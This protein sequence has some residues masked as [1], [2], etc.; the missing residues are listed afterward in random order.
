MNLKKN[1]ILFHKYFV[2]M[3]IIHIFVEIIKKSTTMKNLILTITF[4][5]VSLVS[6]SQYVKPTLIKTTYVEATKIEQLVLKEVNSLV[7]LNFKVFRFKDSKV[8]RRLTFST[9]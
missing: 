7:T 8:L 4:I 3:N 2:R 9:I 6:F 5:L 1:Q